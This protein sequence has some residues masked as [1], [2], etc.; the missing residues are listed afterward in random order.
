[1]DKTEAERL[2]LPQPTGITPQVSRPIAPLNY[3]QLPSNWQSNSV[4]ADKDY[5]DYLDK[6][7]AMLLHSA[8]MTGAASTPTQ[9]TGLAEQMVPTLQATLPF[10]ALDV[11]YTRWL[12][13]TLANPAKMSVM[14]TAHDLLATWHTIQAELAAARAQ[15]AEA[16][17]LRFHAQQAAALARAPKPV[18]TIPER[19]Q[20]TGVLLPWVSGARRGE[21]SATRPTPI[22]PY[23]PEEEGTT[24]EVEARRVARIERNRAEWHKLAAQHERLVDKTEG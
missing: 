7:E 20:T 11:V 24:E 14:V 8:M 13:Q 5:L 3:K 19:A 21:A 6:I 4:P 10:D 18:A 2:A 22:M 17:S 12:T 15:D 9:I 1:M 23:V 16:K